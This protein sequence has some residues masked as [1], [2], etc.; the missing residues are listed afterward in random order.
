MQLQGAGQWN[1]Q[2]ENGV[3]RGVCRGGSWVQRGRR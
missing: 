3:V 1:T 2:G